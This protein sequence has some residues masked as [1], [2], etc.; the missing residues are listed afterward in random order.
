MLNNIRPIP[1]PAS[2]TAWSGIKVPATG[3]KPGSG[4]AVR[5]LIRDICEQQAVKIKQ[6][7]V[8]KDQ[9]QRFVSIPPPGTISRLFE[10]RK[11][12]RR[13]GCNSANAM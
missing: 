2:G 3:V 7:H 11:A 1:Q 4:H 9:V 5:D 6:G 10:W 12:K 13:T 8:A